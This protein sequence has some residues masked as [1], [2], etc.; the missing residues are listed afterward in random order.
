MLDC[1]LI[2]SCFSPITR[3]KLFLKKEAS[4]IEKGLGTLYIKETNEEAGN[5]LLIRADN[6]LGTIMMNIRLNKSLPIISTK[7]G[8]LL[9]IPNIPSSPVKGK[10]P[11]PETASYYIKVK[12]NEIRDELNAQIKSHSV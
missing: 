4:Y 5:Q 1:R 12:N 10:E 7:S 11:E 6:S 2:A 8:L 3:C 9:T